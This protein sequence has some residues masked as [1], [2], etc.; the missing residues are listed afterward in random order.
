MPIYLRT[1][2][3]LI[4]GVVAGGAVNMAIILAG[5][6]IIPPPAGVDMTT[7]EGLQASIHLLAPRHF[8]MPFLAHALG[9]FAGALIGALIAASHRTFVA[10]AVG[11]FFL[12]GGIAASFMIPAP[13][14]FIAL[15]LIVAYVPM[16]WLALLVSKH[17]RRP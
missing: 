2:L 15:D 9:T 6:H 7:A 13:A 11:V 14:W 16:A 3:A 5:P 17:A 4:I 8:I 1:A 12:C 10:Y